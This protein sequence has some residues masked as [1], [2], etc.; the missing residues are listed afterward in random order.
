MTVAVQELAWAS[1]VIRD[2]VRDKAYQACPVGL[3]A[4]RYLRWMR[5]EYGASEGTIRAYE[6]VLARLAIDHA[7]LEL[8]DFE[9]PMG[10]ERLRDFVLL[11]Y[12]TS[13]AATRASRISI[14]KSF[15]GWAVLEGGLIGDPTRAIRRPRIPDPDRGTFTPGEVAQIRAGVRGNALVAVD[16]LFEFGIRKA[17]LRMIQLGDYSPET[18]LLRIQAKGGKRQALPVENPELRVV[19]DDHW[20]LRSAADG[21][22]SE[23]LIYPQRSIPTNRMDGEQRLHWEDR[24]RPLSD[25]ATHTWWER[26]LERA[27]VRYLSIHKARHTAATRFVRQTG[28][29]A[30]AQMML[31][32]ARQSTTADIYC[33]L[34]VGD[35]AEALRTME[36]RDIEQ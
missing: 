13:S 1:R 20:T 16:V 15:F 21:W 4:R 35:L 23:Y 33:H 6:A 24:H 14:L 26:L 25:S 22:Q 34:N 12:G 28:N 5:V 8:V 7:D 11:H 36:Q 31:G 30:L 19:M 27:G 32:H 18:R 10:T 2:A 29:L 9:P 3:E 17:S